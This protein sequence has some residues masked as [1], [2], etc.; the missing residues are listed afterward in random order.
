MERYMPHSPRR[1]QDMQA[2]EIDTEKTLLIPLG[3]V[4]QHGRHLPLDTD[5]FLAT[6]MCD[7]LAEAVDGVVGPSFAHGCRSLP[8][9]GGGELFPGTISMPGALFTELVAELMTSYARHGHRRVVLVNGHLENTMFAI[10]GVKAA[11]EREPLDALVIDWW[12]ILET[13]K[14]TEIF[15]GD[16]PGWEAEHAGIIETSL[17]LYVAPDRV[18]TDQI[19]NRISHIPAPRHTVLPERPGL[20]DPSGVLRT[21]WGSSPDI[22]RQLYDE[23]IR[24][25]T[26]LVT[27]EFE[28]AAR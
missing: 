8:A 15:A 13:D 21:A 2:F 16:F 4:E 6:A 19:A 3:A 5:T 1:L 7:A 18:R 26:T 22:G 24:A 10:E 27:D 28:P 23:I 9:S 14:L 20:V 11:L 12:N 25:A 17:M